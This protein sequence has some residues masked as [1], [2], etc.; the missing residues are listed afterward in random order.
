M[1]EEFLSGVERMIPTGQDST[2]ARDEVSKMNKGYFDPEYRQWSQGQI[3]LTEDLGLSY[4]ETDSSRTNFLPR[5]LKTEAFSKL[6]E[7]ADE[8]KFNRRCLEHTILIRRKMICY[9]R[10]TRGTL[11][12][13]R[14]GCPGRWDDKG[15]WVR[16]LAQTVPD[17]LWICHFCK[18]VFDRKAR[19]ELHLNARHGDLEDDL[20]QRC[21]FQESFQVPFY[22]HCGFCPFQCTNWTFFWSRHVYDHLVGKDGPVFTKEQ[23]N[24]PFPP[25][26]TDIEQLSC[27][28]ED[29]SEVSL[30][31]EVATIRSYSPPSDKP[32]LNSG[33][34]TDDTSLSTSALTPRTYASPRRSSSSKPHSPVRSPIR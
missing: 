33:K 10:S 11:A 24:Q 13:L 32:K 18:E 20:R 21:T 34:W 16:H 2:N 3:S 15:A 17:R 25:P 28:I 14:H 31:N 8:E 12:C 23:W 4:D 30:T 5:E 26:F 6:L 19:L 7:E 9:S 22:G 1:E 29:E 27:T